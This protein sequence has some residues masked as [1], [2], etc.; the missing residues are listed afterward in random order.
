MYSL[1]IQ[2]PCKFFKNYEYNVLKSTKSINQDIITKC[3][4]AEQGK[5]LGHSPH[6][7]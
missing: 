5:G 7:P 4:E 6:A 3:Q 2:R 1:D